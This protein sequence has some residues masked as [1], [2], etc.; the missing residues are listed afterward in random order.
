MSHLTLRP[1]FGT[2]CLP[3]QFPVLQFA[4]PLRV[5]QWFPL[6]SLPRLAC[7][8]T[9]TIKL[10]Y[11]IQFARRPPK[12]RGIRSTTVLNQNAPVWWVEI[13]VLLAKDAIEPVLPED[14][15]SSFC[16]PCFIV[17]KKGS[18]LRP[19]LDL[20][21]LNRAPYKLP[22]KIFKCIRPYD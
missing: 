20:R 2:H 6:F 19:I 16:S 14:L 15:E 4:A 17:P 18:G 9:R 21:A 11:A 7:W 8:L 12:F 5:H 1:H 3:G 22:F 13:V 10:G